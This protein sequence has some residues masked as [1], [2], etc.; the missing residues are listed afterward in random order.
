MST[1]NDDLAMNPY[2][3]TNELVASELMNQLLVQQKYGRLF[4]KIYFLFA[5]VINTLSF[6]KFVFCSKIAGYA[7]L[8][9]G[10]AALQHFFKKL[11]IAER[12]FDEYLGLFITA[13]R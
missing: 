4:M 9:I 1:R 6:N 2:P 8:R 11:V 12:C 10:F 7:N 13:C 5:P 3:L